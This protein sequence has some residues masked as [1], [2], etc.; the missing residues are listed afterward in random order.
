[1]VIVSS[2]ALDYGMF[3]SDGDVLI[4]DEAH[5]F[6]KV[7]EAMDWERDGHGYFGLE[8][9]CLWRGRKRGMLK[10]KGNMIYTYVCARASKR[11]RSD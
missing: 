2:I 8:C 4:H 10:E 1:M 11:R 3:D 7:E 6:W 5:L 9:V